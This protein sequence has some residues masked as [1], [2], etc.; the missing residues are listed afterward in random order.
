MFKTF[1]WQEATIGKVER[2]TRRKC[3]QCLAE[4]FKVVFTE[5][6]HCWMVETHETVR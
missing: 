6:L 5:Y 4:T 1:S 2:Q 3:L